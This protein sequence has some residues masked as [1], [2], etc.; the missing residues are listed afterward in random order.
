MGCVP[1]APGIWDGAGSSCWPASRMLCLPACPGQRAPGER[2][3][4]LTPAAAREPHPWLAAH[5]VLRLR[6]KQR[7]VRI[8]PAA[9]LLQRDTAARR[10]D[11][12]AGLAGLAGSLAGGHALQR[13]AR[14][15]T[16]QAGSSAFVWDSGEQ[17]LTVIFGAAGSSG[18]PGP[19]ISSPRPWPSGSSTRAGPGAKLRPPAA[20]AHRQAGARQGWRSR[21]PARSPRLRGPTSGPHRQPS[22]RCSWR[23]STAAR[24][25]STGNPVP[26]RQARGHPT[27]AC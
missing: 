15:T 7:Y 9:R 2:R 13:P 27:P 25:T 19:P 5:V 14:T 16:Y 3:R 26:S 12:D 6:G 23:S 20:T 8:P 24:P 17:L 4:S 10:G 1:G 22:C 18:C 21:R 11:P